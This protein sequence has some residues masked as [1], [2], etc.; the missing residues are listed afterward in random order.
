MFTEQE[1]SVCNLSL[2]FGPDSDIR[3]LKTLRKPVMCDTIKKYRKAEYVQRRMP[4]SNVQVEE[5]GVK[6]VLKSSIFVVQ[7][8]TAPKT[9]VEF[10]QGSIGA[11]KSRLATSCDVTGVLSIV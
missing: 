9:G 10:R 2:G 7:K 1:G 6:K 5:V 3:V 11:I 4:S 8:A